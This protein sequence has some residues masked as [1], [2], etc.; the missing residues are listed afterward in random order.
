MILK[1]TVAA[2]ALLTLGVAA[3]TTR[4]ADK[5]VTLTEQPGKVRVE[6]NGQLFTEYVYEG[7]PRPYLYPIIGPTGAGVTRNYPMKKVEGEETDHIHHRSLWWGHRHVNGFSFWEETGRQG[8]IKH[9]K[10][11]EIKGGKDSGVIKAQSKWIATNN[12]L[13]ATDVTTIRFHNVKQGRMLDYDITITAPKDSEV[14]FGDDKDAAM[15]IRIAETM[16][17]TH[18]KK[19]GKKTVTSKGEG[20][21]VMSTGVRDSE[22]WGKRAAWCDYYGPVEGKTVGVA[23]FDHPDNPRHPT[24]WHVRDYGLFAANPFGISQ[25]EKLPNKE[26]GVMKIAPGQSVTFKYR[27]YWHE[28]DEKQGKVAERYADYAKGAKN[29]AVTQK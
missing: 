24:W 6:I 15:A 18:R 5:G 29:K 23:I 8:T 4:A 27:F 21:I 10:F 3:T 13:V 12:T 7:A 22:T 17:L 11:L 19:E 25:F 26:A 16:R 2:L 1:R 20:H 14:V 9:D 28:G